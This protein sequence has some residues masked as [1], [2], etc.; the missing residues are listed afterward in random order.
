MI[1]NNYKLLITF[2]QIDAYLNEAIEIHELSKLANQSILAS[3][4]RVRDRSG[5]D[6]N[7]FCKSKKISWLFDVQK[8]QKMFCLE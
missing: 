1:Y 8:K 5:K 4:R 6:N 7:N 3:P 2:Q